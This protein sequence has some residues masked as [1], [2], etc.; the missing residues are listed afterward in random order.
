M[1]D[2]VVDRLMAKLPKA[3]FRVN[4]TAMECDTHFGPGIA[5]KERWGE[6]G[7]YPVT[8]NAALLLIQI[9]DD[10]V[11]SPT[12]WA[13]PLLSDERIGQTAE[14]MMRLLSYKDGQLVITGDNTHEAIGEEVTLRELLLRELARLLDALMQPELGRLGR[15]FAA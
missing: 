11:S 2:A 8:T 1:T 5:H 12:H 9:R 4:C 13:W 7:Y 15:S 3:V 10:L 14:E 6:D